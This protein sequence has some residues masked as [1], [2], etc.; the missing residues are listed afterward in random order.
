[1]AGPRQ[2]GVQVGDEPD[3][4]ADWVHGEQALGDESGEQHR[5]TGLDASY[6]PA[7]RR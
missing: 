4:R 2:L 7:G 5:F 3:D 6:S 1:M